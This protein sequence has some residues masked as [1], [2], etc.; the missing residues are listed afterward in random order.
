MVGSTNSGVNWAGI[1]FNGDT[2]TNYS[3][4]ELR[5][6]GS[7]VTS[8]ASANYD[9]FLFG[10]WGSAVGASVVDLLDPFETTKFKTGKALSGWI[11]A[12]GVQLTSGNWRNTAAVTSILVK[13]QGSET[14][15]IGTRISIYG[16]KGS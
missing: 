1:Q 9:Y 15:R 13:N 8:S 11:G 14:F 16:L 3:R 5:G 4:H 12:D 7:S 6:N 2:G 10:V